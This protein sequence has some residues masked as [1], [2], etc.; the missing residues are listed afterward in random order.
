MKFTTLLSAILVFAISAANADREQ[1]QLQFLQA[2]HAFP[3]MYKIRIDLPS[4]GKSFE[5]IL[6]SYEPTQFARY[7]KKSI[8]EVY[9]DNPP[10]HFFNAIINDDYNEDGDK[11]FRM[12][13]TG[14]E[15][16]F[17]FHYEGTSVTD[18]PVENLQGEG[19]ISSDDDDDFG[20]SRSR[21]YRY[22]DRYSCNH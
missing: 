7:A 19:H 13:L 2:P 16:E 14:S 21:F 6:Y 8:G 9:Y 15:G 18:G 12:D 4:S 5:I 1:A 3:P 10:H 11:I 20:Y 22:Q 17:H